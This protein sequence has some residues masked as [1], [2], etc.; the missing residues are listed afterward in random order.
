[1]SAFEKILKESIARAV[2]KETASLRAEV[3]TLQKDI[4]AL[5]KQY[6]E[7]VKA[8]GNSWNDQYSFNENIV[9]ALSDAW[10]TLEEEGVVKPVVVE[11]KP[12]PKAKKD[13]KLPVISPED[14]KALRA[15]LGLKA[16]PFA[17]LLGVANGTYASWEAGKT[18]PRQ[19]ALAKIAAV[20]AMGKREFARACQ[21]AGIKKAKKR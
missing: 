18:S 17:R 16:A 12:A 2:R 19:K 11:D 9:D 20:K 7:Y 6:A 3:A 1:M 13:G 21:E 4:K 10:K 5:R 15:K 8:D 14:L